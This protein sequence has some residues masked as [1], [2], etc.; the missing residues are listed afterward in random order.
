LARIEVEGPRRRVQTGRGGGVRHPDT[1]QHAQELS[2][3]ASYAIQEVRRRP[4]AMGID[5]RLVLVVE[6]GAGNVSESSAQDWL[7]AGL[8]LVDSSAQNRIVAFSDDA[9]LERFLDRLSSYAP[10]VPKGQKTAHYQA[11]FDDIVRLRPYE[12]S[13]RIGS[14]IARLLEEEVEGPLLF[15]VE[16]WYPGGVENSQAWLEIVGRSVRAR[17]GEIVDT[18]VSHEA[19]LLLARVRADVDVLDE[20][21]DVDLVARIDA[22]T[23]STDISAELSFLSADDL[24]ELP[25]ASGD[26]PVVGLVDSGVIPA[27]PVLAGTI[28]DAVS[29]SP[30]LADGI[31]RHGHGTAVASILV[32]GSLAEAAT[33]NDYPEPVCSILSVRVLDEENNLPR[34]RLPETEI[35]EAVTYLAER[36]VRIV[37]LSVGNADE[38]FDGGKAPRIA[39]VLDVLA[40]QRKLVIVVPTGHVRPVDYF[41]TFDGHSA[42][43][44]PT[45][46]KAASDTGLL[47]PG[48]A[49][50]AL[51]VG[52]SLEESGSLRLGLQKLGQSGWPAPFSRRGP[53]IGGHG[54]VDV[55]TRCQPGRA[56]CGKGGG[57]NGARLPMGILE[58]SESS[59]PSVH[60]VLRVG[61]FQSCFGWRNT[62]NRHP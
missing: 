46:L 35:Y 32:R 41:E 6:I 4:A 39:A 29:G 9:E 33:G 43:L 21:L 45:G 1:A 2:T 38:V 30:A 31:D 52:G 40:K 11:F 15:D 28:I 12:R 27:H 25:A 16:L 55:R 61:P 20:L 5:P 36:G 57:G 17:E 60:S 53:G 49:A 51:A 13:D 22:L 23:A 47:D 3:Q 7:S 42:D 8:R 58:P 62:Q 50:L 37:N 59:R 24:G 48:P 18:F 54:R 10:G 14:G 56:T 19:G 44:Y 34:E 26:A